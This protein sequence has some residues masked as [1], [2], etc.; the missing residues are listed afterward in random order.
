MGKQLKS[1][2]IALCFGV[3]IGAL[4]SSAYWAIGVHLAV[5]TCSCFNRMFV[6]KLSKIFEY[7][8][9]QNIYLKLLITSIVGRYTVLAEPKGR[10][11]EI[12]LSLIWYQMVHIFRMRCKLET[13]DDDKY[14]WLLGSNSFVSILLSLA[15]GINMYVFCRDAKYLKSME[16]NLISKFLIS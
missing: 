10:Q 3:I 11:I 1:N 2:P 4:R 9:E 6:K 13:N 14:H 16:R 8:N 15:F 12:V 5:R 7:V